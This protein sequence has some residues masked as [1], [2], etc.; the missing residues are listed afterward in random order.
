MLKDCSWKTD[1]RD[2][3]E[4]HFCSPE[5][6]IP[7][8]SATAG[9]TGALVGYNSMLG[10]TRDPHLHP[11]SHNTGLHSQVQ[12]AALP[13]QAEEENNT[14][15]AFKSDVFDHLFFVFP[16]LSERVSDL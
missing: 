5:R 2:D 6:G 7:A 10:A 1:T 9:T 13:V 3:F 12:C 15:L 4:F 11:Y 8:N 16:V 14:V